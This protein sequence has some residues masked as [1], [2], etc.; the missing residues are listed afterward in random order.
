MDNCIFDKIISGEIPSHKIYE[1]EK[2]FAFLDIAPINPGHVLVIPKKHVENF[3]ELE[4]EDYE[5]MMLVVKM[6]S[7]KI[8]EVLNPEKVGLLVEGFEV[9]HAHIHV[10]PLNK[11]LCSS[12]ADKDN[13]ELTEEFLSEMAKKLT[14]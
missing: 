1:D 11:P 4:N 2:V 10:I 3:Y 6:V 13:G 12:M 5:A 9:D 14:L 7:E 8:K